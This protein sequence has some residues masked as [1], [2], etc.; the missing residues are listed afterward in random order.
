MVEMLVAVHTILARRSRRLVWT[1]VVLN[2][3]VEYSSI[4][5]RQS[6]EKRRLPQ[7]GRVRDDRPLIRRPKSFAGHWYNRK[8]GLN[9][10]HVYVV[11]AVTSIGFRTLLI[12]GH[13]SR[14]VGDSGDVQAVAFCRCR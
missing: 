3:S 5:F 2:R 7:D 13:R 12:E 11:D 14:H 1:R 4:S 6:Q 8:C 9:E 10:A